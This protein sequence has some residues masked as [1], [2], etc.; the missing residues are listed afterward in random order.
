MVD[1]C[2]KADNAKYIIRLF[3]EGGGFVDIPCKDVSDYAV[4]CA[5][6]EE[7]MPNDWR[8]TRT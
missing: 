8:E 6:L 2:G 1:R 3:I 4:K 7:I 5:K